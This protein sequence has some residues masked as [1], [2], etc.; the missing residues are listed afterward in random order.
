MEEVGVIKS[1]EGVI[2]KVSVPRK[3]A[4]EGCRVET[5]KPG[6]QTMEIEA[7]NPLKAEVG[8]KVK[9]VMKPYSYMKGSIIVY[10]IPAIALIAGAVL[11]KEVFSH[12]FREIDPDIISAIVGFGAFIISFIVIKLWSKRLEKKVELKPVIEEILE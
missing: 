7:L 11:G 4:C 10:G 6:E 12:Y 1:I 5:C 9:V 2:A 8:Q 3:S